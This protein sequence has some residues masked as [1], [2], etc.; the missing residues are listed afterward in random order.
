M[1]TKFSLE[2]KSPCNQDFNTMIPNSDGSFCNSCA[3]NVIDLSTKTNLEVARF[4]TENKNNNIC[5]RLKTSQLDQEFEYNQISKINN[6][7]YAAVLAATVLVTTNAV[8]QEKEILKTEINST[9]PNPHIVGKI[10]HQEIKL[11][12]ITLTGK[13]L[14]KAT[15][16]P[17]STKKFP[18]L[19]IHISGS[20]NA[21][22]VDSKTGDYTITALLEKN[23]SEIFIM[24]NA[25]NSSY[26]KSIKINLKNIKN[27][28]LKLDL[29]IDSETEM[30][31]YEIMGGLGINYIENK[32]IKNS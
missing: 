22:K 3:K 17:F 31:K 8:G 4:I 13:I 21:V 1:K 29:L 23:T 12:S 11:V 32:K 2:I 24:V 16:R 5:A 14:E 9:K 26:S 28:I 7:K 30:E 15:K 25:N 20:N 19:N 6:F 27:N 10:A 18:E